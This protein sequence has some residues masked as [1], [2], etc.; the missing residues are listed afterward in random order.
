MTGVRDG[1]FALSARKPFGTAVPQNENLPTCA[2]SGLEPP[3]YPH[4]GA[5]TLISAPQSN[6]LGHQGNSISYLEE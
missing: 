5:S 6:Q 3:T 2:T 4:P 1:N